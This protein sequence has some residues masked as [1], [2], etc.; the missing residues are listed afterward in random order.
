ML[1]TPIKFVGEELPVPTMAPTVGEHTEQ[2]LRETLGWSDEQIEA[3]RGRGC[4]RQRIGPL[5]RRPPAWAR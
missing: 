3:A 1:P 5:V 4:V 2:V